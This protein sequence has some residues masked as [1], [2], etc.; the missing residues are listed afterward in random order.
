MQSTKFEEDVTWAEI[1]SVIGNARPMTTR[2]LAYSALITASTASLQGIKISIAL[3]F[4]CG[5]YGGPLC[6]LLSAFLPALR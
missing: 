1:T 4:R 3:S 6:I 2:T 5:N